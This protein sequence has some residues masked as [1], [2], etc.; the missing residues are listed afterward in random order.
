MRR[1]HTDDTGRESRVVEIL[2]MSVGV[3]AGDEGQQTIRR[4]PAKPSAD[5]PRLVELLLSK[6]IQIRGLVDALD[7]PPIRV[8]EGAE[9]HRIAEDRQEA[10][11]LIVAS[12][13]HGAEP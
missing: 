2:E 10:A 7:V 12:A 8:H 9:E 11:E 6:G 3:A 4:E 1:Q 5:G 13:L